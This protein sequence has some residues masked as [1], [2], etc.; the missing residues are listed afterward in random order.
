MIDTKGPYMNE[1][2]I[3]RVWLAFI[4]IEKVRIV[5][6]QELLFKMP[7]EMCSWLTASNLF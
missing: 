7:Q 4:D 1:S 5:H 6:V 3:N 2:V